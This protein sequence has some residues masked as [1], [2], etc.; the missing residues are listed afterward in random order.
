LGLREAAIHEAEVGRVVERLVPILLP[1]RAHHHHQSGKGKKIFTLYG[2]ATAP[3]PGRAGQQEVVVGQEEAEQSSLRVGDAEAEL[4]GDGGGDVVGQVVELPLHVRQV[5]RGRL[6]LLLAAGG[7]CEEEQQQRREEE[8]EDDALAPPPEL[9]SPR[10]PHSGGAPARTCWR[11]SE[12]AAL[13]S[14]TGSGEEER[15]GKGGMGWP[16][17]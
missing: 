17:G 5:G 16:A 15:G 7:A 11:R 8:G 13:A 12:A 1:D 9:R 4:V 6:D 10:I 2:R 3:P 14:V